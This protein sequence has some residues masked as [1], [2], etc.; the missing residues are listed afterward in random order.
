MADTNDKQPPNNG[1]QNENDDIADK[2]AM[3]IP[4]RNQDG[5]NQDTPEPENKK[6][7]D[8]PIVIEPEK[9]P[10]KAIK[11]AI[12][13]ITRTAVVEKVLPREEL[14]QSRETEIPWALEMFFNGDIDLD[15]ELSARFASMPLMST[16]KF[17]TMGDKK[18]HAVATLST[19]DGSAQV[20][21]DIN[22][23]DKAMQMSFTVG[24]MLTLRF[25]FSELTDEDRQRWLELMRRQQGGLSFL[26]GAERWER[27]Y[28][29]S[30]VRRYYT[31]LYAF[32]NSNFQAAIRM[33]PEVTDK[34]LKWMEKHWK[35]EEKPALDD[36]SKDDDASNLL[37]W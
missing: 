9:P 30:V 29:I 16:V 4:S 7:N 1:D 18:Q 20:M 11:R 8:S 3:T 37:S 35:V 25:V 26:W 5:E 34:L 19:Q 12:D 13:V 21:L 14:G 33:T 6:E 23:I 28:I 15:V 10:S 32:S 2:S 17:R 31:N 27:D 22:N 36:S 24:A